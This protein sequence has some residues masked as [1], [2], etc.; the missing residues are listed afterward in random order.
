MV[1]EIIGPAVLGITVI[2]I[3][4][5]LLAWAAVYLPRLLKMREA[6][7]EGGWSLGPMGP[8]PFEE[9]EPAAPAA[10][11]RPAPVLPP[12]EPLASRMGT[13]PDDP[14]VAAAIALALA[15]EQ[16]EQRPVPRTEGAA[17]PAGS[18]WAISGRW[19]TMQARINMQKR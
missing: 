6:G 2:L 1:L 10:E 16:G 19:Q 9:A 5:G 4:G 15:L 12:R 3:F 13:A 8:G 17:P 7:P 11:E 14:L 18:S